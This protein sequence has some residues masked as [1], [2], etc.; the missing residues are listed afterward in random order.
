MT[1]ALLAE[2]EGQADVT[3]YT[4][5]I[6]T[7]IHIVCTQHQRAQLDTQ[8]ERLAGTLQHGVAQC[9]VE[10][11]LGTI[12]TD[13]G[14]FAQRVQLSPA[15]GGKD[16]GRQFVVEEGIFGTQRQRGRQHGGAGLLL[17]A[18]LQTQQVEVDDVTA[19]HTVIKVLGIAGIVVLVRLALDHGGRIFAPLDETQ[20][21]DGGRQGEIVQQAVRSPQVNAGTIAADAKLVIFHV[22]HIAVFGHGQAQTGDVGLGTGINVDV[23][24]TAVRIKIRGLDFHIV[25]LQVQVAGAQQEVELAA[26]GQ[27]VAKGT[28]VAHTDLNV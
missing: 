21:S 16:T 11:A 17:V 15:G 25:N 20:V 9:H 22:V 12:R 5:R 1:V 8:P 19:R 4:A 10:P 18:L 13:D 14:Q 3:V 23:G 24:R 2:R 6:L 7:Q 26:H 28:G 27:T